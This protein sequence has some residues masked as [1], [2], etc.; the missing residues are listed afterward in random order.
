MKHR[1]GAVA[2]K[3]SAY[4]AATSKQVGSKDAKG[5]SKGHST[6]MRLVLTF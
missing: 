1:V 6:D 4:V 3:A 5:A 2:N